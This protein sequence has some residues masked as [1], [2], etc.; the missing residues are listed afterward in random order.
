M[1]ISLARSG[2][3]GGIRPPPVIVDTEKLPPAEGAKL[4]ALV[5]SSGIRALTSAPKPSSPAQPD[6]FSYTLTLS[7]PSGREQKVVLSEQDLTPE[8][9]TLFEAVKK[10]GGA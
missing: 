5:Q 6:R 3:F 7:D 1:R 4:E 9:V 10:H 2:G 8:Q